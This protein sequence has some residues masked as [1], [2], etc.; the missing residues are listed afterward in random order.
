M[1]GA[2]RQEKVVK[3]K[4]GTQLRMEMHSPRE[5]GVDKGYHG[6]HVNGP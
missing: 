3:G 2:S 1:E 4:R 6:Y 5:Q